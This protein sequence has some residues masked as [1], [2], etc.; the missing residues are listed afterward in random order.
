VLVIQISLVVI[1]LC[2]LFLTAGVAAILFGIWRAVRSL[3]KLLKQ[4]KEDFEPLALRIEETVEHARLVAEGALDQAE[5]FADSVA[6]VRERAE[7]MGAIFEV[8]EED[9]EKATLRLFGLMS[10]V[11]RFLRTAIRGNRRK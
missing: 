1:A 8:L 7:R 10:G 9:L 6:G 3:G 2:T 11:G 5:E 4:F